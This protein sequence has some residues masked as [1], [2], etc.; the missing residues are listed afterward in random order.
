MPGTWY[1]Q[2]YGGSYSPGSHKEC[3]A[4]EENEKN[5]EASLLGGGVCRCKV[6]LPLWI[7]ARR[8]PPYGNKES[9]AIHISHAVQA[10]DL[11][12][13]SSLFTC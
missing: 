5:I 4:N 8:I 9:S 6:V 3:K 10:L 11:A 12:Y 2:D 13:Y 1:A 7:A